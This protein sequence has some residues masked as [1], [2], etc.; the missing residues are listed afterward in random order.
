MPEFDDFDDIDKLFSGHDKQLSGVMPPSRPKPTNA[1][2]RLEAQGWRVWLRTLSPETF[3]GN[4]SDFHAEY[5][6]WFW[7]LLRA[8]QRGA[9]LQSVSEYSSILLPWGRGLAKS[10]MAEWSVIA[11]G[12]LVTRAVVL[13][14][15]STTDMAVGHLNNI[16]TWLESSQIRK[17]YPGMA[18][19]QLNQY[20]QKFGWRADMLK[21]ESG[22]TIYALGLEKNPR[23][24]R[25]AN[26]RPT[27]RVL[28]D[29]DDISDSADRVA[30]KER[31]IGGSILGTGTGNTIDIVAQNLI[32]ENSVM[33]RIY[34]RHSD[35]FNH[36]TETRLVRAFKEDLNIELDGTSWKLSG[37]P[38]WPYIDLAACQTY[39]GKQGPLH[40]KAEY[41]HD[42]SMSR[43][44]LVLSNYD[45]AVHVITWSEFEAM[46]GE[47][48]IPDR[49]SKYLSHDWAK[50]KSQYH[51][52]VGSVIAISDQNTAL[53]GR[54]FF[55][56]ALTFEP[57]TEPDEVAIAMLKAISPTVPKLH[58]S[59]PPSW[60]MLVKSALERENL[61]RYITNTTALIEAKHALL[62]RVIPPYASAAR[63]EKNFKALRMSHEA[64]G[65]RT[66][67]E[68][69]FG[70]HFE[71][72]NPGKSG[73]AELVNYQMAVDYERPHPFRADQQGDTRF[74]LIVEDHELPKVADLKPDDIH[75]MSLVRYQFEHCRW[76]APKLTIDGLV[77]KQGPQ[78]ISDDFL[79]SLM[80]LFYDNLPKARELTYA[81]KLQEAIP[82]PYR[83][84]EMLKQSP[85]K[86]GLLPSQELALAW[87][88][89][90]AKRKLAGSGQRTYNIDYQ[91]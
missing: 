33:S 5:W 45:D 19:A 81:E 23:G 42:F 43:Q 46:F 12:A 31:I 44:G 6:S 48:Q 14:I 63:S 59:T 86:N 91:G 51:A 7:G 10:V 60:D 49:W 64:I 22:L 72:I 80:F 17:Y 54:I 83:R 50:T 61:G 1:A 15:S 37:T 18:K 85:H 88:T 35:L 52:C 32:H 24:I 56:K 89:A 13:Y 58:A 66:V 38:E 2:R 76:M 62:A 25:D 68:T 40:F 71:P 69:A 20:G 70:L 57:N 9:A 73:G 21:T 4:F 36:R 8:Q 82:K 30:K 53:P 65:P 67:Y 16:Q 84:D 77:E 74:F 27:L 47:R 26:L 41:Q 90:E 29:F 34:H 79:N 55:S 87:Q 28:D 11:A 75:G 3:H 78:K 39:L